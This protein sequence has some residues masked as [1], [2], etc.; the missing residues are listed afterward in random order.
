LSKI[1]KQ[2]QHGTVRKSAR[3]PSFAC[4]QDLLSHHGRNAP[5]RHAILAPGCL[6]LTYG[7]LWM[8]TR[9]VVRGLRSL[10]LGRTDRVAMVLPEG[11][12]AA[13]A[14]VAVA[15]GAVCVPLNPGFTDDEYQRYFGELRLAALITCAHLNSASRRA[16]H[17]L[18]IP[19]IDVSTRPHDG[20]GA[21]RCETRAR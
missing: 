13:V 17:S 10:G 5:D 11:P 18:G 9:D 12:E 7:A 8:Q 16:A 6:P 20:A 4:L 15:A 2:L 3:T 14:M 19:V 1:I 21:C